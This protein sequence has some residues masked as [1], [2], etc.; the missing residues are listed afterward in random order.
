[1]PDFSLTHYV[2]WIRR[3]EKREF[4]LAAPDDISTQLVC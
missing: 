3:K 4:A 2:I 1:M